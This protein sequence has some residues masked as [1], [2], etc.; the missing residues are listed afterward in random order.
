MTSMV[1]ELVVL[2]RY[3]PV[4][5]TV[6]PAVT[7]WTVASAGVVPG[8]GQGEVGVVQGVVSQRQVGRRPR[9][10]PVGDARGDG[11]PAGVLDGDGDAGG[12]RARSGDVGPAAVAA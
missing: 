2:S 6:D 9:A 10:R 1:K 3:S 7:R 8:A 11:R 12:D 5:A 4:A